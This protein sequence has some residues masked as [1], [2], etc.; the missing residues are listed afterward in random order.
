MSRAEGECS[1]ADPVTHAEHARMGSS[2]RAGKREI[3][4]P[5]QPRG[6]GDMSTRKQMINSATNTL[7]LSQKLLW[8]E[9][10]VD[11]CRRNK[12]TDTGREVK[13]S[14]WTH[15]NILLKIA[16]CS[17]HP[18]LRIQ[19]V[20][21]SKRNENKPY[22]WTIVSDFLFEYQHIQNTYSISSYFPG[23]V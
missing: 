17:L 11:C 3:G 19:D 5:C 10:V 23:K 22:W 8:S 7:E 4:N 1:C 20:W 12:P 21:S 18:D 13:W 9:D 14:F 6:Y 2:E 16:V 15:D